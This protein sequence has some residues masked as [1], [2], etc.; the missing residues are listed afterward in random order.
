MNVRPVSTAVGRDKFVIIY[1]E[2]TAV[3]ARWDTIMMHSAEPALVCK[4]HGE[5]KVLIDEPWTSRQYFS[6]IVSCAFIS[7]AVQ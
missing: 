7:T 1:L 4:A 3:T 6:T 2:L 5:M